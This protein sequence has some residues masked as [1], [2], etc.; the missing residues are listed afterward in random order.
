MDCQPLAAPEHAANLT[1]LQDLV[2]DAPSIGR[3][4]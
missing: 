3:G 1:A 4:S 2:I